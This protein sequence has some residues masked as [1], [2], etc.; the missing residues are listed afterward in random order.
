MDMFLGPPLTLK[1]LNK[2]RA[3]SPIENKPPVSFSLKIAYWYNPIVL[4][5]LIYVCIYLG[6]WFML[7]YIGEQGRKERKRERTQGPWEMERKN[8]A[9]IQ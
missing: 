6:P 4:A 9:C 3:A 7:G 2:S 1:G 8:K 5:T